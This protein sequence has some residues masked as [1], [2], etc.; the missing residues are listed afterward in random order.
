M[1]LVGSGSRGER[2][3]QQAAGLSDVASSAFD[4][5]LSLDPENESITELVHVSHRIIC[6]NAD[7][8]NEERTI[9]GLRYKCLSCKDSDL[10]YECFH[11]SVNP[12]HGHDFLQIPSEAWL[13]ENRFGQSR[14]V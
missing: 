8:C 10:C 1:E 6:D 9:R 11:K 12:H 14:T 4:Q 5:S 3:W 2:F 13:M 7:H